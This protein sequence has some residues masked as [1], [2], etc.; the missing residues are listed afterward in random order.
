MYPSLKGRPAWLWDG[1]EI[2]RPPRSF[3]FAPFAFQVGRS[4]GERH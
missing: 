3:M 1:Y 2:Q 4:S